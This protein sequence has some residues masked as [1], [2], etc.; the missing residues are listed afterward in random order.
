M[1]G[2]PTPAEVDPEGDFYTFEKGVKE[3]GDS[4]RPSFFFGINLLYI[5]GFP[6][7]ALDDA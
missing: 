6:S 5:H 7:A 3:T 2:Q 4:G 1:L